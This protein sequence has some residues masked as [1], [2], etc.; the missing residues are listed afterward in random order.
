MDTSIKQKQAEAL[1]REIASDIEP[2]LFHSENMAGWKEHTK[3][4]PIPRKLIGSLIVEGEMTFIFSQANLG[5]SIFSVQCGIALATGNNIYMGDGIELTNESEA[6]KVLYFDFEMPEITM[7]ERWG[8]ELHDN[9]FF[10]KIKRGHYL[11]GTPKDIFSKLKEEADRI[12]SKTIIIDNLT[13]IS[14]DLEKGEKAV[15]FMNEFS[16]IVRDDNFTIIVVSHTPKRDKTAALTID[17]LA[18]SSKLNQIVDSMVGIGEPKNDSSGSAYI[19][20]LKGRSG[21]KE[22]HKGNVIQTQITARKDGFLYHEFVKSSSEVEALSGIKDFGI[23]DQSIREGVSLRAIG[24]PLG[25]S[26]QAVAQRIKKSKP[27]YK[28]YINDLTDEQ[29]DEFWG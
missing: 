20:H 13:A 24:E 4:L 15:L 8:N 29:K 6:K 22:F 21:K 19:I 10:A 28:N 14:S 2:G 23:V 9:M 26:K 16:R 17:S 1:K 3:N 27:D 7:T 5:K 25:L 18:G 12:G 11:E